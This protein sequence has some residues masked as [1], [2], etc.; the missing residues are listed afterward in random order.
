MVG[1]MREDM[2][3][4]SACDVFPKSPVSEL[5]DERDRLPEAYDR[6]DVYAAGERQLVKRE[7][8]QD[9][10]SARRRRPRR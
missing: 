2:A 9:D 10:G 8:R 1:A 4:L 7:L 3:R 5:F 6:T